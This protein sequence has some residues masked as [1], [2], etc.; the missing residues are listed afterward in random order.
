MRSLKTASELCIQN[1]ILKLHEQ[2]RVYFSPAQGAYLQLLDLLDVDRRPGQ[3][4]LQWRSKD[5]GT[6]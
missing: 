3:V 5:L 1:I 6:Q 4:H 2:V